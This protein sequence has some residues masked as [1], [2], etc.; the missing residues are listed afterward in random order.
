[1][2]FPFLCQRTPS[3][4]CWGGCFYEC[5]SSHISSLLFAWLD[6]R[7]G[8]DG[9]GESSTLM[10]PFVLTRNECMSIPPRMLWYRTG[11]SRCMPRM[12][13]T[14]AI[15]YGRRDSRLGRIVLWELERVGRDI[16]KLWGSS[17]GD[18]TLLRLCEAGRKGPC[19]IRCSSHWIQWK[20][21]VGLVARSI[22]WLRVENGR[23]HVKFRPLTTSFLGL[24]VHGSNM[25]TSATS[26]Y[27]SPASSL[28][29]IL[30]GKATWNVFNS[31]Q[32]IK[33]T[34]EDT[35]GASCSSK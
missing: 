20:L 25:A 24:L 34:A 9:F 2:L 22:S 17:W 31:R 27:A 7:T 33:M 5:W 4:I 28:D 13:R 35:S 3:C 8:C 21:R 18:E 26:S 6:G 29:A 19:W 23:P 16:G 14:R 15:P 12:Q 32:R 10:I 30:A 11:L 1:M